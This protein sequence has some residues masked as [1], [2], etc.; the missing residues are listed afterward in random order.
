MIK[1]STDPRNWIDLKKK[2]KRNDNDDVKLK[3]IVSRSV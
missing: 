1:M 3:K 2:R